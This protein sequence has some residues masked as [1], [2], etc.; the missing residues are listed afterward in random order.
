MVCKFENVTDNGYLLPFQG[1]SYSKTKHDKQLRLRR[2][3][4]YT[5]VYILDPKRNKMIFA[6][7]QIQPKD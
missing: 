2:R 6:N 3:D 4:E 5:Y 1:N 7:T